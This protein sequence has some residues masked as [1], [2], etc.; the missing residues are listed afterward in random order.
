MYYIPYCIHY[1]TFV[2]NIHMHHTTYTICIL[3]YIITEKDE[4]L[5]EFDEVYTQ[6]TT[7]VETLEQHIL[8]L[9]TTYNNDSQIWMAEKEALLKSEESGG[10]KDKPE[11]G[12][13]QIE[14][15]VH[16]AEEEEKI[17]ALQ[18]TI[19]TLESNI[20]LLTTKSNSDEAEL[21]ALREHKY[22]NM[23]NNDQEGGDGV[24]VE[25]DGASLKELVGLRETL[26]LKEGRLVS[27]L[28][29]HI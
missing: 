2:L 14:S 23:S 6:L 24:V 10:G 19:A 17:V 21:T 28:Y 18:H 9:Q 11:S 7:Q 3:S 16:L 5:E 27:T 26:T 25:V 12:Q 13:I 1:T 22:S 20:A 8:T 15:S 4:E 29:L